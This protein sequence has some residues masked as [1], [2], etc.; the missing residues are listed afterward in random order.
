MIRISVG[1]CFS[2]KKEGRRD[3]R[4]CDV[5]YHA[6]GWLSIAEVSQSPSSSALRVSCRSESSV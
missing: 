2:G 1:G 4:A 3:I 5:V 6:V